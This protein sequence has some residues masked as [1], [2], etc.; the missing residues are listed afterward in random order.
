M[1]DFIG[2]SIRC[3][4]HNGTVLLGTVR[5]IS[6][7]TGIQL[8]SVTVH[9]PGLPE[10]QQGEYTVPAEQ[11]KQLEVISLERAEPTRASTS[12][13]PPLPVLRQMPVRP[14]ALRGRC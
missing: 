8:G 3:T 9:A 13:L 5:S 1:A 14:S 4:L 7:S 6:P 10:R 12:A 2:L 11:V